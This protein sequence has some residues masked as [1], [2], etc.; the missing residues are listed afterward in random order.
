MEAWCWF[1]GALIKENIY[2]H[3]CRSGYSVF[4]NKF[5]NFWDY[6]VLCE[7][8]RELKVTKRPDL[9]RM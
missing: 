9:V 5:M 1:L 3:N 6:D 4:K 2:T 7:V 8:S